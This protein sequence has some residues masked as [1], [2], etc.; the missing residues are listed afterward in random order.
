MG[1]RNALLSALE[2]TGLRTQP[3]GSSRRNMADAAD[4]AHRRAQK[5]SAALERITAE[6]KKLHETSNRRIQEAES[7]ALAADTALRT[8]E[9]RL[10]SLERITSADARHAQELWKWQW[11]TAFTDACSRVAGVVSDAPVHGQPGGYLALEEVFPAEVYDL[12]VASL[13]SGE[14]FEAGTSTERHLRPSEFRDDM[15]R[16]TALVWKFIDSEITTAIRDAA[17]PR[18]RPFLEARY[19]DLF[20]PGHADRALEIPHETFPGTLLL[21]Q[22]PIEEP[23]VAPRRTT[24]SVVMNLARRDDP[25]AVGT[26]L[27]SVDPDFIPIHINAAYPHAHGFQCVPAAHVA[28]RPNTAVILVNSRVAT[29]PHVGDDPGLDRFTYEFGIGPAL[30]ELVDLVAKISPALQQ[31]WLGLAL[32]AK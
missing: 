24:I 22:G 26:R 19:T 16:L 11:K 7:R 31:P 15:P 29:A 12:I 2:R 9:T 10:A 32:P 30:P 14:W 17:L 18:L 20:G 25:R 6:H 5:A 23:Q 27:Y 8:L 21:R 3:Q 1:I 4:A 28:S 13:P